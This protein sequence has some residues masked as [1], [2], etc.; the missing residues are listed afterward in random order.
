MQ[1]KIP[2]VLACGAELKNTF[3]MNK[4]FEFYVSHHIGDIK[5]LETLSSFEAGIEHF[6]NMF[7]ID[8]DILAHDLHPEYMSSKFAKDY[9]FGPEKLFAVQHHHA[10][11]AS[12]MADN[13]IDGDVIGVAFDGTGLGEDGAIWGGEFFS[14]GYTGFKREGHLDYVGM[15]G[16]DAAVNEPWRMAA[17][18]LIKTGHKNG[19]K[20]LKNI[21][22]DKY[23]VIRQMLIK[24][25]NTPM[26]SS[27]G[28]LFDAVAGL[29]GFSGV[30]TYEGQAAIELEYMADKETKDSYRFETDDSEDTFKVC[31]NDVI[32]G[33]IVDVEKDV[34]NSVI[35]AKFHNTVAKIICAGCEKIRQ[36]TG[37]NRVALSG[38]VFQNITLLEKSMEI[39]KKE[40]FEV[41]IHSRVPTNDGCISLGQ[42]VI[43]LNRFSE[44]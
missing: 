43:A 38:G 4:N 32:K 14:G 19:N 6:S 5:N 44:Q 15:P 31:V 17:S 42:A 18:Y 30:I 25:I 11:I 24:K 3:C 27:V 8:F 41:F 20:I 22:E 40:K 39:L 7:N 34:S 35:S 13:N 37:L 29:L 10:H 9:G 23:E 16:G 33:I 26:T 12:C 1:L 2:S 28:R 36:D 21:D